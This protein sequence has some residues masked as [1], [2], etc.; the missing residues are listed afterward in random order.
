[1]NRFIALYRAKLT[2]ADQ[3]VQVIKSGDFIGAPLGL[4]NPPGLADALCRRYRELENVRIYHSLGFFSRDYACNPELKGHFF[5]HTS[6]FDM[7]TR[8]GAK[9]GMADFDPQ[10]IS[11]AAGQV[12]RNHHLNVYWTTASPMDEHGYMTT[13]VGCVYDRDFINAADVV[14]VEVN[15]NLPRIMGDALIHITEVDYVTENTIPLQQVPGVIPDERDKIIGQ[16][17]AKLVED[18]STIQLGIGGIPNAV[19]LELFGKRDLGIHSEMFTDSMVEL[20]EAGVITNRK[21]TYMPGKMSACFAIGTDKLYKFLNNNLGTYFLEGKVAND[22]YVIGQNHKQISI[23]TCLAVDLSGQVCS[24]S[25]GPD[26]YSGIGGAH[27][28]QRGARR[29]CGG[30]SFIALHSTAKDGAISTITPILPPG[31]YVTVPRADVQ[32]IVTEYGVARLEG[33]T[34]SERARALI[35][36]AHPDFRSELEQESRR[37]GILI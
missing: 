7:G 31:S 24:E 2:T 25:F 10:H 28:F 23:N 18:G 26:Q 13:G 6:F 32:H 36:I 15:E 29:S 27:D 4:N 20:Y 9:T 16:H 37:I 8:T 33:K 14:M 1:M 30:K 3:A 21:K 12:L 11:T 35:Q 22:E 17:I 19:G 34:L 5:C